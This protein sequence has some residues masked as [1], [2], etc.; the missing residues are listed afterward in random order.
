M[1]VIRYDQREKVENQNNNKKKLGE[2]NSNNTNR[3]AITG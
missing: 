2:R 3:V 1:T